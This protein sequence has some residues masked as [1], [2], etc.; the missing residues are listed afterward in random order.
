METQ[1][2]LIIEMDNTKSI[3]LFSMLPNAVTRGPFLPDI[4]LSDPFNS[5]HSLLNFLE[6][7]V[8]AEKFSSHLIRPKTLEGEH[9]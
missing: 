4:P 1:R 2:D 8:L 6:L 5:K 7:Y 9:M 3:P